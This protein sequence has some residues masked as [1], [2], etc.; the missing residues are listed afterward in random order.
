MIRPGTLPV[1]PHL[2]V[3]NQD[4]TGGSEDLWVQ[5]VRILGQGVVI[6]EAVDLDITQAD[7]V[8]GIDG[9]WVQETADLRRQEV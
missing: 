8:V 1:W 6:V 9:R 4:V 3:L 2:V 5:R 7:L